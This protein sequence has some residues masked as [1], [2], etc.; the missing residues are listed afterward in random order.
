MVRGLTV[1]ASAVAVL[2]LGAGTGLAQSASAPAVRA[3]FVFNFA[4]FTEW[5]NDAVRPADP[6]ALCVVDDDA[7]A[8]A[9]EE[10]VKGR[11]LGTRPLTV[12]PQRAGD[13]LR[14]CAL[15]YAAQLDERRATELLAP[16]G[17]LPI[18]TIGD[19]ASFTQ[20]G[21]IA[22][23]FFENGKTRFAVNVDAAQRR[24]LQLSSKLLMLGTIVKDAPGQSQ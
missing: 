9:L 23:L 8:S 20:V 7:V 6:L 18:L 22:R 14:T 12:R 17:H 16:L 1:A 24:R 4:K 5:P 13:P 15:V 11:S 10:L 2:A 3:A 19:H 21:G